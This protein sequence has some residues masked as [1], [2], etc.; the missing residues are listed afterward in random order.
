M[1]GKGISAYLSV[2]QASKHGKRK[3]RSERRRRKFANSHRQSRHTKRKLRE[4]RAA[5]E[6]R[7]QQYARR[8][9]KGEA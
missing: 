2:I 7:I 5:D 1:A 8:E 6:R 3:G 4:A 9:A